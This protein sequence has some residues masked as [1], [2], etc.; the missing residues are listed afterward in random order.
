M[1]RA[2]KLAAV[3][4][5]I[6]VIGTAYLVIRSAQRKKLFKEIADKIGPGAVGSLDQFDG[7]WNTEFWKQGNNGAGMANYIL[8]GD[9]QLMNWANTIYNSAGTFDD[10]EQ[11]MFGVIRNV[12]DGIA[13]SQLAD[14][15]QAKWNKDLKDYIDNYYGS[16][17]EKQK[18]V[19][20]LS[21]KP[22]YRIAK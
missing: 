4:G 15:F 8:Q 5:S 20:I 13:L 17:E 11:Q 7:W 19:L 2:N 21:Q 14:K 9:T 10:D 1:K 6:A 3:G 16:K 22:A 12:P 18:L